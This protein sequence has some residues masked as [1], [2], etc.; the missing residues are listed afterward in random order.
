MPE[1]LLCNDLCR[2]PGVLVRKTF[3]WRALQYKLLTKAGGPLQYLMTK[4][5]ELLRRSVEF[6]MN[7]SKGHGASRSSRN[8]RGRFHEVARLV[9][10]LV[11][12]LQVVSSDLA[13][14]DNV[15]G[16]WD[17]PEQDNWPFVR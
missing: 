5:N 15:L 11:T 14:A 6:A 1:I 8:M 12:S 13:F 9:V 10:L 2:T 7:G 17:S 4:E 16:A 3:F